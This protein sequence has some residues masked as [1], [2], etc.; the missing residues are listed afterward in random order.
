M[1][2]YFFSEPWLNRSHT[3]ESLKLSKYQTPF[4]KD[5][6]SNK[7]GGGVIL[8]VKDNINVSRRGDLDFDD[9]EGM[10]SNKNKWQKDLIWNF[11]SPPHKSNQDILGK[12]ETSI[13][14]AIN[15]TAIDVVIIT[16]DFNDNRYSC[17]KMSSLLTNLVL[18]K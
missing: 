12:L 15:D 14:M 13:E 8:Y 4:R 9:L 18:H 5:R 17:T 1:T 16:G 2:Y 11:V 10:G 3:D 6:D 7:S